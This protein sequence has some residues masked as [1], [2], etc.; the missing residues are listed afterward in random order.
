M[1][2]KNFDIDM[3]GSADLIR[4]D[5]TRSLSLKDSARSWSYTHDLL[6]T[7]ER[8]G[9]SFLHLPD[10]PTEI[11]DSNGPEGSS[12]TPPA[13]PSKSETSLYAP[14][15]DSM[16]PA[17]SKMLELMTDLMRSNEAAVATAS[18]RQSVADFLHVAEPH[19]QSDQ[20]KSTQSVHAVLA[21]HTESNRECHFNGDV[22]PDPTGSEGPKVNNVMALHNGTTHE[23][24]RDL[25]STGIASTDLGWQEEES[26]TPELCSSASEEDESLNAKP[27]RRFTS[28]ASESSQSSKRGTNTENLVG[29][30]A[31]VICCQWISHLGLVFPSVKKCTAADGEGQETSKNDSNK[32]FVE[33]ESR[34]NAKRRRQDE[35]ENGD[36]SDGGSSAHRGGS[37][38][39]GMSKE[40]G[41]DGNEKLKLLAC[42]YFKLD[43]RRYS[44]KN[45]TEQNYHGCSSRWLP[46]IG[47]LK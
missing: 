19:C 6:H 16:A 3:D 9:H 29:E 47:R 30:L 14:T 43:P 15:D 10:S 7:R 33:R 5:S 28:G 21:Q 44:E 42:P 35:K 8:T 12:G 40:G 24:D 46:D 1:P 32:N 26:A 20:L 25:G 4:M 22:T 34:S 23:A 41:Q 45:V 18:T 11:E 17:L 27:G 13:A 39:G 37:R 36:S 31:E 38:R 2:Q